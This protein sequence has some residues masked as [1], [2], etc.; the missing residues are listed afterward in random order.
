MVSAWPQKRGSLRRRSTWDLVFEP[1]GLEVLAANVPSKVGLATQEGGGEALVGISFCHGRL[2]F[3]LANV[4]TFAR[5]AHVAIARAIVDDKLMAGRIVL[6][7]AAGH[8]V[9][10]V[11]RLEGI[12]YC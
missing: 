10:S 9:I 8:S 12:W 3:F 11:P 5:L 7:L 2:I 1:G 6:G 4:D